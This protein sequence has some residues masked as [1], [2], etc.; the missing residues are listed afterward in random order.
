[1][2][3]C[4][5]FSWEFHKAR[6]EQKCNLLIIEI[7][8][9]TTKNS[10][11]CS[12]NF[13]CVL[14]SFID[15]TSELSNNPAWDSQKDIISKVFNNLYIGIESHINKIRLNFCNFND[16]FQKIVDWCMGYESLKLVEDFVHSSEKDFSIWW[17]LFNK[18]D[19]FFY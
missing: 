13:L 2:L 19:P 10:L 16:D 9:C 4:L 7:F 5:I 1:M 11:N 6:N 12:V 8:L 3:R 15:F 17:K 18:I 14:I